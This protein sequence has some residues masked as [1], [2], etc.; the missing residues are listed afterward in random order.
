MLDSIK[1]WL[2]DQQFRLGQMR[3]TVSEMR[4]LDARFVERWNSAPQEESHQEEEAP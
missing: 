3:Q 2:S 1:H 4:E